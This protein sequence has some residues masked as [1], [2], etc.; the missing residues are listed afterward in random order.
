MQWHVE[1]LSAAH[2]YLMLLMC[3]PLR[4]QVAAP[5]LPEAQST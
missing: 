1:H 2:P 5:V 3:W 4:S